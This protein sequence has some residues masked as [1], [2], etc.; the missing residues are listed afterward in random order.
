M[1][2]IMAQ[3][4]DTPPAELQFSYDKYGKPALNTPAVEDHL[5]F[6]LSHSGELALLAVTG[7]A[8]VGVDIEYAGPF[9]NMPDVAE[10]FFSPAEYRAWSE[11]PTHERTQGFYHCWTRKEAVIKALGLGLSA[12]LDAF[13]VPVHQ[14]PGWEQPQ[15]R[16]PL[17]L[18]W[19][20]PLL[21]LNPAEGYVGAL[22][23]CVAECEK[24]NT[25]KMSLY[26]YSMG[27]GDTA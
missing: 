27:S 17:P 2:T 16:N 18:Q 20:Y 7:I 1:R 11:L 13:D 10:R 8:P 15:T 3:Y 14:I 24:L 5:H 23:L 19:R 9:D 12:P 25:F 22:A 4:T 21:H 6:N 26:H